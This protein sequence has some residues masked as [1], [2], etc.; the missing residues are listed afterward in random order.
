[1]LRISGSAAHSH[2]GRVRDHNED[3]ML[4]AAPLF[5]VADG[6][7]GA[8]AGEVA[9]AAV[10][11]AFRDARPPAGEAAGPFLTE[12]I[13]AANRAIHSASLDEAG[14]DGMGTTVV[15]VVIDEEAQ[16]FDVAHVGD[17]R[18]YLF[19]DGKLSRVTADHSWVAEMVRRGQLTEEE[20]EH[21]PQKSLITRALGP[22]ADVEVDAARHPLRARDLLILCS[23]GLYDEVA[24]SDIAGSLMALS[25]V[26]LDAGAVDR[27]VRALVERAVRN[28]GRDNVTVIGIAVDEPEAID[29]AAATAETVAATAPG[30][31]ADAGSAETIAATGRPR[32]RSPDATAELAAVPVVDAAPRRRRRRSGVALAVLLV[33]VAGLAVA[34]TRSYF[35]G[36][37]DR[38][39]AV[40]R[41]FPYDVAGPVRLYSVEYRSP[42]AIDAVPQA[43]RPGLL[44][45]DLRGRGGAIG[46]VR[47]LEQELLRPSTGPPG[48]SSG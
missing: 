39:L 4:A 16:S 31:G 14:R 32:F 22:D 17:S 23:D 47:R 38:Q 7:G 28:G 9:S 42:L 33:L 30:N 25:D 5:V 35:V 2:P 13:S 11:E 20:A 41:G 29:A 19:R 1:M 10:V 44:D 34:W 15:A 3:S 40:Y 36:T 6:V 37:D 46:E 21:H 18:L 45:H 48:G 43:R 24:D 12:R 26:P 8:N 27:A